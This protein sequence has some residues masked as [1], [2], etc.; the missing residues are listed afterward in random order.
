[1]TSS[2]VDTLDIIETIS[3][4]MEANIKTAKTTADNIAP[5][6]PNCSLI[7]LLSLIVR[8]E[9]FRWGPS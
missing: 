6:K 4:R 7:E 3:E 8:S 2:C 1:M 9:K 5:I